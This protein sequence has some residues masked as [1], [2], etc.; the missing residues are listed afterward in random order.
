M[1]AAHEDPNLKLDFG[2]E[3]NG[4]QSGTSSD[5]KWGHADRN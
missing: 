5:G 2:E 1:A 3:K 4:N